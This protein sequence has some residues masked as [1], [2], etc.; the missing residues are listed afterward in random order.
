MKTEFF[1]INS[2]EDSQIF[3]KAGELLRNGHLVCFPTETVY[4][5]GCNALDGKAALS[6][7]AAKGRPA[8]NPLIVHVAFPEDASLYCYTTPLFEK[9][10]EA[11]MPGP[12]TI[13]LPKKEIIPDE[14]TAGNTTVAIRC[15]SNPIAHNLI[16]TAKVPIAAP[17]ANRSGYPSP[18]NAQDVLE[19]MDGRVDMILDGGDC[20]FGLES[21]V[22]S[23]TGDDSCTILRPGAVTREM[24]LKICSEV[25]VAEAVVDPSAV[26]NGAVPSPGMKYKHYSPKAEVVLLEGSREKF[27]EYVNQVALPGDS[28]LC[29]EEDKSL[30]DKRVVTISVGHEAIPEEECHRLFSALREADKKESKHAFVMKPKTEGVYLALYNRLIRAASC[31]ITKIDL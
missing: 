29:F 10:A 19:D 15:P 11:F 3:E 7:F 6:V 16:L 23:L 21:T 22:I 14:V 4:G 27:I 25:F 2:L 30:F 26:K 5:L 1:T 12:L 13:I 17:S 28:V 20:S 18:T 8:D 24:L 9:L 31:K